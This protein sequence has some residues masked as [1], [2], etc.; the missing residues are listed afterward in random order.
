MPVVINDFQVIDS[1][2]EQ[3]GQSAP[4]TSSSSL[5]G[6]KPVAQRGRETEKLLRHIKARR[7]RIHAD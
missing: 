4:P 1:E 3:P 2:P 7:Y 6:N 5:A